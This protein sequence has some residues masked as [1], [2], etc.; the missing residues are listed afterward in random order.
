M[1]MKVL[2]GAAIAATAMAMTGCITSPGVVMDKS[3]P[4]NQN[5]YVKVAE[6]VSTTMWQLGIFGFPLPPVYDGDTS[7][8]VDNAV[9]ASPG[10]N[11]YK[12]CLAK[13]PGSNA[14]IEYTLDNQILNLYFVTFHRSTLTGVP[15]KTNK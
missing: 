12:R 9:S 6:E 3:K 4:M 13:A 14:L 1:K 2:A 11:L 8:I 10:R 5:A 15:V 7:K